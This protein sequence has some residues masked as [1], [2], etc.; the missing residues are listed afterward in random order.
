MFIC[1]TYIQIKIQKMYQHANQFI[2][3]VHSLDTVNA[4]LATPI[5]DNTHP[6]DFRSAFNFR[7]LYRQAK[8][9]FIPYVHF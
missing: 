9:Q 1:V 6:N 2:P 4:R 7:Y 8:N 3:S 5:F